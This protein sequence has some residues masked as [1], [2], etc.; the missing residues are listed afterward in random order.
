MNFSAYG[1]AINC[2]G[3]AFV[4]TKTRSVAQSF[5]G[6]VTGMMVATVPAFGVEVKINPPNP[7][8]GDT[9]SVEILSADQDG[10]PPVV[11]ANNQTYPAFQLRRGHYRTFFPTTPLHASGRIVVRV[12]DEGTTRNLALWLRNRVFPTQRIWLRGGGSN[13]TQLELDRVAAFKKLVTPQKYWHGAFRRP[14]AGRVSTVFG[15]RRYYNGVFANDY[16]HSGV[17]YAGSTGST[18]VAPARGRVALIGRESQG[19]RVHGNTV[20]MD[21]GQGVLSIFLHLNSIDVREGE[22]VQAGQ[23]IG[24]VGATG[25]STGP[26]LHWGVYVHG[27]AVDPVPWRYS[28][29]E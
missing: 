11:T 29:F 12:E 24:T 26:H 4:A 7:Q 27:Q 3:V 20:G 21:H 28:G 17:D 9:V 13:A 1:T 15:V 5:I 18:V 2:S 19:F 8:L 22:M 23:K 16:Y 25:A 6:V 10:S 14:N